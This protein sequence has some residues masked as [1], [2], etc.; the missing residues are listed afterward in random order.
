MRVL[1]L[2]ILSLFGMRFAIAQT[3]AHCDDPKFHKKVS[4]LISDNIR[5]VDVDDIKS[6]TTDYAL[7]DA[8]EYEEYKISHIEGAE[9]IGYDNPQFRLLNHI[10]KDQKIYIYCSVGY[11][12][13]K[14]AQKL[15][16]KG[17]NNVYNVYGSIFEWANRGYPL[18]DINGESTQ[19]VHTY[20]RKWSKWVK[21][22]DV[23]KVW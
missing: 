17:Y 9:W 5:T 21:N 3:D 7:L 4:K 22:E 20:N 12:S 8:R 11:R 10:P 6:D 15:V 19:K 18:Q 14:L 23:E 2:A 13:D 16:K 1:L